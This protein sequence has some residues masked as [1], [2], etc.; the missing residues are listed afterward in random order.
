MI[1]NGGLTALLGNNYK[2]STP[3]LNNEQINTLK[4]YVDNYNVLSSLQVCNYIIH[5]FNIKYTENGMTKLLKRL[6]YSY[7]KPKRKPCKI[8]KEAQEKFIAEYFDTYN[9]YKK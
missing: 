3:K 6:G 9:N 1:K 2:G 7:K 8:D 4:W 5:K